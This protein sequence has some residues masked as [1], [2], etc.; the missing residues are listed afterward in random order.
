MAGNQSASKS[1]SRSPNRNDGWSSQPVAK[2]NRSSERSGVQQV[3][4]ED[5]ARLREQ[6]DD[7]TK[8]Y[9]VPQEL[10]ELARANRKARGSVGTLTPVAPRPVAA[11]A[12]DVVVPATASAPLMD[13]ELATEGLSA[14]PVAFD[15]PT[16]SA[17]ARVAVE[18]AIVARDPSR[19]EFGAAPSVSVESE[20]VTADELLEAPAVA[21]SDETEVEPL[22]AL[23]QPEPVRSRLGEYAPVLTGTAIV[24]AYVAL[25]YLANALFSSLP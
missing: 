9:Q 14:P 23:S 5:L 2:V 13:S 8:N 1:V 21:V 19:D 11:E 22:A 6:G 3:S 25:C 4:W 17:L 10:I 7:Q 15:E 24:G 20:P 16:P 12:V 18:S